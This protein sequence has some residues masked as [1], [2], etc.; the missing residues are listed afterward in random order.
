MDGL[1]AVNVYVLTHDDGIALIDAGWAVPGAVE[2]LAAGLRE[3]GRDLAEIRDIYVTHIHRDH[4]TLGPELRRRIGARVHLGAPEAPGVAAINEL[5]SNVPASSI[6]QLRRAGA[7]DLVDTMEHSTADEPWRACDWEPADHWLEP[8]PISIGRRTLE[9]VATPGHTKGH[10]VFH[11]V[12]GGLLFTGDHVLPTITP[13]I[14]FE[15]GEWELPLGRYLDSLR[16]LL[17]RPDAW[18]LPAHGDVADSVHKRV[19]QLLAHHD[20]R[21]GQTATALWSGGPS[22]GI[23]VAARLTWTRRERPFETLDDF[24]QM[25]AVCETMAHLDLLVATGR[26]RRTTVRGVDRFVSY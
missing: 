14:G 2:Q 16:L 1:R 12:E 11:D 5:A 6:D 17:D 18:L 3:I 7:F 13:S 26:L 9:A 4:Y 20:R 21:L 22:T 19:E 25:I 8:G 10:L 24:N 15:L 23:E